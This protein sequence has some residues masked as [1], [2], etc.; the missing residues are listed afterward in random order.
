MEN[1]RIFYLSKENSRI[2]HLPKLTNRKVVY[3]LF[4]KNHTRSRT[5]TQTHA[6]TPPPPHRVQQELSF[7]VF[8]HIDAKLHVNV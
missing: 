1:S 7:I 2:F 4:V 8:A 3:F 5:H 6:C